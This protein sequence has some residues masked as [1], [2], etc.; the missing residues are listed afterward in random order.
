[1]KITIEY[2]TEEFASMIIIQG[3]DFKMVGENLLLYAIGKRLIDNAIQ[4]TTKEINGFNVRSVSF[5]IN[6]NQ[7]GESIFGGNKN[8]SV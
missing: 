2:R 7:I 4:N 5:E 3:Y 6:D 1:M 8:E